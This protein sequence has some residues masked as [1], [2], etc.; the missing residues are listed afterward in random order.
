MGKSDAM[1]RLRLS[2]Y[3][4]ASTDRIGKCSGRK[5]VRRMHRRCRDAEPGQ[6]P[7]CDRIGVLVVVRSITVA[8]V[9]MRPA[10]LIDGQAGPDG[11][12]AGRALWNALINQSASLWQ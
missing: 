6:I 3:A 11:V 2:K 8:S 4:A 5:S 12:G 7:P 9:I 10:D 1:V